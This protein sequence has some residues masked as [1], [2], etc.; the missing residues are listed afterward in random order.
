M[1]NS[2]IRLLDNYDYGYLERRLNEGIRALNKVF[3]ADFSSFEDKEDHYELVLDVAEDAKANNVTVDYDDETRELSVE[4]KYE[5]KNYKSKSVVKETL[6][7]NADDETVEATV[8][9]GKLTITVAKK[10]EA[11]EV[12][13]ADDR[14]VKINRK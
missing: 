6:P 1:I 13:V 11:E 4:Y 5:S 14:I 12:E 8:E 10:A 9:N 7:V 3:T 2:L